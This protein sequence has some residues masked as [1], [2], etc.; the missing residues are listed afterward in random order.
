V[1]VDTVGYPPGWAKIA[2][3]NR[4]P[5]GAVV[6]DGA[7]K[8]VL[9]FRA[10]DLSSRGRDQASGDPCWQGD[11]SALRVPGRY[12]I[13][14]GKASSDPFEVREGPYAETLRLALKHFYFQRCRTA[15]SPPHAEWGGKAWTREKAC[16][17]HEGIAWDLADH[18]EKKR[19]WK[20]EAGWHDA[21]NFEMYVPSTAPTAQALLTAFERRPDL[22]RDG[23]LSIPE[24]GNGIPDLLDEAAWGL[25]W[26]LSL[27]EKG[28]GVRMREALDRRGRPRTTLRCGGSPGSGRRPP[29]RPAPSSPRRPGS[30]GSTT[31]PWRGAVARR[32][33]P[34]G[35]SCRS[36]PRGSSWTARA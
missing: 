26:V 29:P 6:L 33:D 10:S 15:L 13:A 14:V 34:R 11:F 8:V 5:A 1:K 31:R 4:D 19:R 27:Q 20:P 3:F 35:S 2:V 28:G 7:G 12:R 30:T 24:S 25:R 9:R 16:H 32:P 17:L 22:F 18:P 21:G 23:D 36:I